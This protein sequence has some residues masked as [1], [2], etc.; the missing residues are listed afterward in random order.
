[1]TEVTIVFGINV[2]TS[3]LKR[4]IEPKWGKTGTQVTVFILAFIAGIYVTYGTSF[5]AIQEIVQGAIGLFALA[6]AFYEVLW[7]HIGLFKGS[8]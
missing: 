5:A 8:K 6:V 4:W 3:I 1:M 7:K 2:L